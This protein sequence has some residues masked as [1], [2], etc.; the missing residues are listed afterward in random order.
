[1]AITDKGCGARFWHEGPSI[2]LGSRR[3]DAEPEQHLGAA[4]QGVRRK[5]TSQA[6]PSS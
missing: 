3:R 5:R 4:A 6:Q 1:M 2:K